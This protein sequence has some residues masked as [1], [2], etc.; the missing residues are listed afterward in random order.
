MHCKLSFRNAISRKSNKVNM[1]IPRSS[2]VNIC[3]ILFQLSWNYLRFSDI[4]VRKIQI[5]LRS[6]VHT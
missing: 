4:S 5:C 3:F 2:N 6:E 1:V